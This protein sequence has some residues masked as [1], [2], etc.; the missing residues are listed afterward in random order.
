MKTFL[1]SVNERLTCKSEEIGKLC[2]LT[3]EEIDT[4]GRVPRPEAGLGNKAPPV[5]ASELE[6]VSTSFIHC[7][8]S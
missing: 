3:P 2:G 7:L 8:C 1:F 6:P 5:S 4:K